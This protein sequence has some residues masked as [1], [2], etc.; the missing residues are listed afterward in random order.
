MSMFFDLNHRDDAGQ[1]ECDICVVGSGPAAI[2]LAL[3]FVDSPIRVCMLESGGFNR[4][5]KVQRLCQGESVG[6]ALA[7]G[8]SGSRSRFFGGSSNCWAGACTPLDA[9]DFMKRDWVPHSGWPINEQTLAPYCDAAQKACLIGSNIYDDRLVDG[10]PMQSFAFSPDTLEMAYWQFSSEPR[11][12]KH[13]HD[14][15]AKSS[16]ISVILYANVT[17]IL[18]NADASHVQSV[19]VQSLRGKK[20]EVRASRFVLAC[21]GIENARLLLASNEV[22]SQGLGNE[23]DLVGRFFMEHPVCASATVVPERADDPRIAFLNAFHEPWPQYQGTLFNPLIKTTETFQQCHRILNSAVYVVDHDSEFSEGLMAAVRVRQALLEGRIPEEFLQDALKIIADFRSVATAAYGRYVRYGAARRRLGL[24]V[25]AETVPNPDSRVTLSEKRDAFGAPV[26][27]LNWKLTELDRRTMDV[28]VDTVTEEFA[29]LG[30]AKIERDQW[31]N[32][33]PDSFP[34]DM[35]GG[36]HHTGT[37][38]MSRNP[39]DGVVNEDCRLH[40]VDNLYIAGS[41]VFPTNSWANPT[42]TICRLAIR[43]AEHLKQSWRSRGA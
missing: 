17:K 5:R 33:A 11:L 36:V 22:I 16:N 4:E 18:T 6:Y 14:V 30:L 26:A 19:L 38:R 2:S 43:L 39:A 29:R 24:K 31:M 15:F 9:I 37:T 27:K 13:Y 32:D 10:D 12:G 23:N 25:Q 8:L 35:R 20:V 7:N 1:I 40:T 34:D 3:Q 28:I 42:L 21:G 41:S